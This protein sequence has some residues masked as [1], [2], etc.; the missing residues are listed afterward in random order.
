MQP[1]LLLGVL[2]PALLRGWI[3]IPA[4]TRSPPRP[5]RRRRRRRRLRRLWPSPRRCPRRAAR[6]TS[7]T[8]LLQLARPTAAPTTTPLLSRTPRAA[9]GPPPLLLLAL[10]GRAAWTRR[11]RRCC[12]TPSCGRYAVL[13]S[14]ILLLAHLLA[15]QGARVPPCRLCRHH[16]N[17]AA[18]PRLPLPAPDLDPTLLAPTHMICPPA[19]SSPSGPTTAAAAT[20]R[21]PWRSGWRRCGLGG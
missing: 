10:A 5:H 21:P 12:R 8:V 14:G 15:L 16:P 9:P 2:Q 4:A 18:V 19:R 13:C 17:P 3:L 7:L 1:P 6:C 11:R 20:R